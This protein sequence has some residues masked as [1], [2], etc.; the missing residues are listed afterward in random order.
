M[1]DRKCEATIL[2]AAKKYLNGHP[3]EWRLFKGKKPYSASEV[4][5]FLEKDPKFRKWFMTNVLVL[6]T[7]VILRGH[8]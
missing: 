7:E 8:R 2:E 1:N 5:T 3:P 6:S 4:L